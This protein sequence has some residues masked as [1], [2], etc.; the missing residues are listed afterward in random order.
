MRNE[1]IAE[2][3]ATVEKIEREL[4]SLGREVGT[5]GSYLTV[6]PE[7]AD[8]AEAAR[9]GKSLAELPAKIARYQDLR[10]ELQKLTRPKLPDDRGPL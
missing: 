10:Y 7:D 2:L 8:P 5:F 4:F 1:R 3:E 9:L 6:T